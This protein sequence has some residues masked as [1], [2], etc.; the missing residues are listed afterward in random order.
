VIFGQLS[1]NSFFACPRQA[2]LTATDDCSQ[3]NT[4]TGNTKSATILSNN[5]SLVCNSCPDLAPDCSYQTAQYKNSLFVRWK[6]A[7]G[8]CSPDSALNL[9]DVV[10]C[11][12][13][14]SHKSLSCPVVGVDVLKNVPK[15]EIY[16]TVQFAL[17]SVGGVD[18][19][20]IGT[21]SQFTSSSV[22][23]LSASFQLSFTTSLDQ[24]QEVQLT[25]SLHSAFASYFH[26][27]P[28]DRCV[29]TLQIIA[30]KRENAAVVYSG[31]VVISE[32][33]GSVNL[34]SHFALIVLSLLCSFFL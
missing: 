11:D 34:V 19:N 31:F 16:S 22:E 10:H 24:L 32:Y 3:S 4:C 17:N 12:V 20:S 14:H 15:E 25:Q 5:C 6:Y 18:L 2:A 28:T 23:G 8:T 27:Y 30:G 1:F 21:I 13:C 9:V 26:I 7:D 33:N 29:V